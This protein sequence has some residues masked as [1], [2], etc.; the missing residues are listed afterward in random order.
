MGKITARLGWCV[1]GAFLCG[2]AAAQTAQQTPI[3]VVGVRTG[4]DV[5]TGLRPAR[6][7]INDLYARGGPEW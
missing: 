7:N 1:A 6:Q 3:P 2:H 4:I 5:K